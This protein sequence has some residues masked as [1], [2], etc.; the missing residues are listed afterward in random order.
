M[1]TSDENRP[2]TP[3]AS[4][5]G[6]AVALFAA[7]TA[8]AIDQ[9]SKAAALANLSNDVIPIVPA[10]SLRLV[11]NP[12]ASFGLGAELGPTIGFVIT[13]IV[14]VLSAWLLF[15]AARQGVSAPTILLALVAGG[16][17]G[18]V[19]DRVSRAVDGPLTGPVVDMIAVEGFAVFNVADV[20]VVGGMITFLILQFAR[21]SKAEEKS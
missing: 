13:A 21:A 7:A 5:A 4:L 16:A 18:N 12:G 2:V 8:L 11:F 20:F 1:Q 3:L 14:I 10:V 6:M 19:V 15:R 9:I 17:W